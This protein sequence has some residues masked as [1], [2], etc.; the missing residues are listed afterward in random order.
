MHCMSIEFG[1]DSSTFFNQTIYLIMT[2]S[3]NLILVLLYIYIYI[4]SFTL[5]QELISMKS[6]IFTI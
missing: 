4:F 2:S 5:F 3:F 1:I 6:L